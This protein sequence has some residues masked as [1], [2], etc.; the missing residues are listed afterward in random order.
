[1]PGQ[2]DQN[3]GKGDGKGACL[4]QE[5]GRLSLSLKGEQK[6]TEGKEKMDRPGDQAR[7][8]RKLQGV[9]LT[10]KELVDDFLV[11][12]PGA[13]EL[14]KAVMIGAFEKLLSGTPP[15]RQEDQTETAEAEADQAIDHLADGDADDLNA[16]ERKRSYFVIVTRHQQEDL[17]EKEGGHLLGMVQ[18][19]GAGPEQRSQEKEARQ[20]G[21]EVVVIVIDMVQGEGG[22]DEEEDHGQEDEDPV[23]VVDSEEDGEEAAL[24]FLHDSDYTTRRIVRLAFPPGKPVPS[25][26]SS[27]LFRFLVWSFWR[28]F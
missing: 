7:P 16:K 10:S 12:V 4:L 5:L 1:M 21:R 18:G 2:Q 24:L 14:E 26:L 8:S 6:G 3:Q 27:F 13:D 17:Q 15:S 20:D 22:E 9:L 28:L 11:V 23:E 25:F 19:Q